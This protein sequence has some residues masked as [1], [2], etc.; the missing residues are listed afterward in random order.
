MSFKVKF[1]DTAKEDLRDI[2]TYI[3][4]QSKDKKIAE[5]ILNSINLA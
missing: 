1:T 3:A 2:A 5:D 4:E